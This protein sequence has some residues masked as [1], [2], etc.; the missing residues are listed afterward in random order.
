MGE[1]VGSGDVAPRQL[2]IY[3]NHPTIVDF[4]DA[5]SLTPQLDLRLLEG[6]TK[7]VEYPLRVATFARVTSV[8][9][10]FVRGLTL[11]ATALLICFMQSDSKSVVQFGE[12]EGWTSGYIGGCAALAADTQD[13]GMSFASCLEH[14]IC[15]DGFPGVANVLANCED[16]CI[17]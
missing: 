14:P 1:L 10:L 17:A 15:A 5:E 16:R 12:Q 8:S 11:S 2:R 7:V 13:T 3:V 4:A 6:E 9:L